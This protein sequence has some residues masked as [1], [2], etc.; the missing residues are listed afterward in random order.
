[1]KRFLIDSISAV[2]AEMRGEIVITGSHGG[3]SAAHFALAH[4][5]GLAVFNDAG[6]GR[7]DAGIRGLEILQLGGVAACTVSHS[8]AR[9][10]EAGSTLQNGTISH[11]NSLAMAR[12]IVAGQSCAKA[13]SFFAK[14]PFNMGKST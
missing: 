1:M 10:G 13:I 2:T 6:V 12:G 7:D 3:S 5:P 14:S 4:P 8:S 11:V 9:I